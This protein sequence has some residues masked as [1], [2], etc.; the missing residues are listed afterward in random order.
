MVISYHLVRL[1]GIVPETFPI[2]SLLISKT[3][4]YW[5]IVYWIMNYHLLCPLAIRS[6]LIG[7]ML[8]VF[9][10]ADV[11]IS[12]ELRINYLHL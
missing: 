11:L 3:V 5:I 12:N 4:T 8:P 10:T 2:R 9:Y 1:I 6:T 7:Y